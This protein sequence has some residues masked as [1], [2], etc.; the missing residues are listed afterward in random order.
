MGVEKH[1]LDKVL[2]L[3]STSVRQYQRGRSVVHSYQQNRASGMRMGTPYRVAWGN[4]NVGDVVEFGQELWKVIPASS[5]PG[6]KPP[7]SSGKSTSKGTGKATGGSTTG[8]GGASSSAAGAA[9]AGTTAT[10]MLHLQEVGKPN[11]YDIL[12]L[13]S[14][15]IVTVVPVLP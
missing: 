8:T 5:Y 10:S 11:S 3:A 7:T 4:V 6:Y 9:P 13:P 1:P 2:R 14:S 12:T 15:Y